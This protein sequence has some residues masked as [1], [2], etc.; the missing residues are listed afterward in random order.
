IGTLYPLALEAL[1]GDKISVGAPFFN[2]TVVW[3]FMPLLL[4]VP[5]GIFLA[6][7][8]GD[9][10]GAAKRLGVGAA[11]ALIAVLAA[12][13]AGGA[14]PKAIFAMALG[15]FVLAG[16]VWEV[17]W[18]AKFPSAALS[19]TARRIWNMRRGQLGSTFGHI[20]LAVTV[21]GI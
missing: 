5:F 18:R 12:S 2:S 13:L 14:G 10:L 3:I 9:L 7:K 19:E 1:T 4:A 6:W 16:S 17:L 20:G 15:A 8:R 11:A 21:I